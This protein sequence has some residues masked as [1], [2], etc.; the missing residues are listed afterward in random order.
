MPPNLSGARQNIHSDGTGRDGFIIIAVL[1]ILGALSVLASLYAAYVISTAASARTYDENFRSEALVSAA[2]EL[3][4]Y[5][6]LTTPEKIRPTHGTFSFQLDDAAVSVEYH[7]ELNRIDLNAAPKAL[8]ARLFMELGV[9]THAANLYADRVIEWRTP[10][11]AK[12]ESDGFAKPLLYYPV[13]GAKF[14][15]AAELARVRDLPPEL[16]QRAL[17]FVTVYSGIAKVDVIDAAPQVI[18]ALPGMNRDRLEAVLAARRADVLDE[19][20]LMLL[21]GPARAY[22]TTKPG[23]TFRVTVHVHFKDGRRTSAQV[24]IL[25]FAAGKQPFSVLSWRDGVYGTGLIQ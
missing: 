14:P 15:D 25:L 10:L 20:N 11:R 21:L 4:A 12:A 5:H 17:P 18:A 19:Q 9:G 24:V 16:V 8:L 23:R 7:S 1:W 3:T 6:E 2:L 22:V 13:R